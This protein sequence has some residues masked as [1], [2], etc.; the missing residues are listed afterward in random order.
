MVRSASPEAYDVLWR[1]DGK[2][3]KIWGAVGKEATGKQG[4]AE[5]NTAQ[6][7]PRKVSLGSL[8]QHHPQ[9]SSHKDH[10]H[11]THTDMPQEVD[12]PTGCRWEGGY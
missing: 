4:G 5:G 8:I 12:E 7:Q 2:S 11:H 9:T 1:T 3:N 6:L 10:S